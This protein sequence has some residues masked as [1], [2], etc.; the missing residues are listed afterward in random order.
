MAVKARSHGGAHTHTHTNTHPTTAANK[1]KKNTY[2]HIYCGTAKLGRGAINSHTMV[3]APDI[4]WWGKVCVCVCVCVSVVGEISD[5]PRGLYP[6]CGLISKSSIS[7][8][9]QNT[10]PTLHRCGHPLSVTWR[11]E[12]G[13]RDRGGGGG[14]EG[15]GRGGKGGEGGGKEGGGG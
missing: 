14:G 15:G 10:N 8:R 2:T 7:N 9:G 6:S 11:G 5:R 4:H 12:G 3:S 1:R 13:T